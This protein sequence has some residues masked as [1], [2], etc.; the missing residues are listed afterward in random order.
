MTEGENSARRT[1]RSQAITQGE[2][3]SEHRSEG[4]RSRLRKCKRFQCVRILVG[5]TT[6]GISLNAYCAAL[7]VSCK[8]AR[9]SDPLPRVRILRSA[10]ASE[11]ERG[12]ILSLDT[13]TTLP[14]HG[15]GAPGR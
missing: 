5:A 1:A 6:P 11:M 12:L 7:A 8:P 13:K 2:N 10:S 4:Y 15:F 3:Q 14:D 9:L